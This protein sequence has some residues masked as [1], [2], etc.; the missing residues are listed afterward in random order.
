MALVAA[1][2]IKCFCLFTVCKFKLTV[3]RTAAG[4]QKDTSL[5]IVKN[6]VKK[7]SRKIDYNF[8]EQNMLRTEKEC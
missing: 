4:T 2:T 7:N 6:I 3:S 5:V 8:I 1:A